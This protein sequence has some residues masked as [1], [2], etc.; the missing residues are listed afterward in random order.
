MDMK[1]FTSSAQDVI[2]AAKDL[3]LQFCHQKLEIRHV[4]LALFQMQQPQVL[5]ICENLGFDIKEAK[6]HLLDLIK[7]IPKAQEKTQVYLSRNTEFFMK[8][9]IKEKSD[10]LDS[11]VSPIHL[12]LASTGNADVAIKSYLASKGISKNTIMKIL[13]LQPKVRVSPTANVTATLK[14]NKIF[15]Q[16]YCQDMN[17][18]AMDNKFDPVIGKEEEIRRIIEILSRKNKNNPLLIGEPG[19]GKTA[20]VEAL[21]QRIIHSDIPENLK[22]IQLIR[23]DIGTLVAGTK[24]RGD[25]ENRLKSVLTEIT[26]S[27]GRLILFID[28]IHTI[29]GAGGA[30][31]SIDAS[32]MLKPALA[33]G[34]IRCIGAT[35][36]N[37]YKKFIEVDTAFTRRFQLIQVQ[38][39]DTET[40][41]AILRGLKDKY[42]LHHGVTIKDSAIVAAVNLS[43]RYIAERFLPDKA[44]DLIDEAAAKNRIEINSVPTEV[45]Q[46]ER[47]IMQ[48]QIQKTALSKETDTTSQQKYQ[49]ITQE[50]DRLKVTCSELRGNWEKEK[51]SIQE[52]R[53]IRQQIGETKQ[54]ELESQ[55]SNNLELAAR[56]KYGTLRDLEEKLSTVE[57]NIVQA[58]ERILKEEIDSKDIASIISRWT[59]IPLDNMLQT[60]KEKLLKLEESISQRIVGQMEA[61]SAVSNAIRRAR[62][63]IQD[64][65][66]PSGSFLFFGPTGVG[67]TELIKIL[68]EVLF[69]S[70]KA[71]VRLDMSEYIEK[72]SVSRLIGAPPGYVGYD[73]GGILTEAIRRKPYSVVLF[74]EIEKGHSE[75]F[76]ILLQIL[77]EGVL[78]DTKGLQVSF[79]N[80]LVILTSNFGSEYLYQN[81]EGSISK[82]EIRKILLQK[83]RPELL[84]RLDDIIPFQQLGKKEIIKIAEIQ[85]LRAKER[86]A[87]KN[88]QLSISKNA[89]AYLAEIGFD[90]EFGARPLKRVIQKELLDIIA[91]KLLDGTI[92]NE[93]KI[94]VRLTSEEK[95]SLVRIKNT[96]KG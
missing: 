5:E 8:I 69:D 66:R 33:R 25:F 43:Q 19:I 9:A 1:I 47:R 44:L 11:K 51:E 12:L 29:M 18:Q 41:I 56:L 20:I 40:C 54:K 55:R 49:E 38:E 24:Y 61:I 78:T 4:I 95:L 28:E 2:Y 36:T 26:I 10:L 72:H 35:T 46:I 39:P 92:K 63:D 68:A 84:N 16:G 96:E 32:N 77:D 87:K 82:R 22:D 75:I 83:F 74:D 23:L 13:R 53:K 37:E 85:F 45:D 67:K 14:D 73:E 15:E 27:E 21:A 31:G 50:I 34:E 60:E 59:G 7:V 3:A 57:K 64:P 70:H 48:L 88:L 93:D 91:Y 81:K 89:L 71:I 30:E 65:D 17:Q 76:N 62:I 42:E 6:K 94:E 52:I 86:L 58:E 79:K 90:P 80:T